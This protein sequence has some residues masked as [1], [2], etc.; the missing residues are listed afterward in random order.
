MSDVQTT[1]QK[2]TISVPEMRK[3]LGL[4]KTESYY[5]IRKNYF[6]VI[7]VGG[8]MRVKIDSFEKW[9][10]SQCRY[11]KIDGS[12][13]GLDYGETMS[14]QEVADTLG[15]PNS[16]AHDLV[17]RER[18][19]SKKIDGL[20]R[21]DKDSFD[22][23]YISQTRYT[24]VDR[25][26]N[27]QTIGH[28]MSAKEMAEMLGVPLRNT[29]YYLTKKGVFKTLLVEGQLRVDVESFEEWYS[30][31]SRYKKTS[32]RNGGKSNGINSQKKK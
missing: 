18:F 1:R 25:T 3:I 32:D 20:L 5:L 7:T 12:P 16:T 11:K 13:P 14:V 31:Q 15:I 19:A 4:G 6:D 2:T 27:G 9:Y 26:P 24:K 29:G 28:T 17:C 22:A 23:W 30:G 10:A 8:K 21:I